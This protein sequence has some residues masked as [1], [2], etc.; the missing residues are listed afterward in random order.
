[1]TNCIFCK[2]I[3]HEIPNYTV[4]E[5]EDV[6]AYLD[7]SQVTKGHTLVIPKKHVADIFE[8]D[9]ELA[10]KVFAKVPQIARAV[11]AHDPAIKGMNILNNNGEFAHQTVFHSH[12]HLIPRYEDTSIDGFGLKWETHGEDYTPEN[13]TT[14]AEAIQSEL[15]EA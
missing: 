6:L 13:F 9:E 8:Y 7:I 4:Y 10:T 15:E 11:K 3:N 12:I 5:D 14:V 2:I 1:M